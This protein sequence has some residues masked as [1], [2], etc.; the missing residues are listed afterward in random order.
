[1]DGYDGRGKRSSESRIV[2]SDDLASYNGYI[3]HLKFKVT[4]RGCP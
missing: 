1:M 2:F 4:L 3:F